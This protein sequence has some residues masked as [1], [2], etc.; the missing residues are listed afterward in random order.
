MAQASIVSAVGMYTAEANSAV[1]VLE[2]KGIGEIAQ[3]IP[4][5]RMNEPRQFNEIVVASLFA[6]FIIAFCWPLPSW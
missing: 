6:R 1:V 5:F 3:R 4:P 2:A